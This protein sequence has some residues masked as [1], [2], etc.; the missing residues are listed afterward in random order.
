MTHARAVRAPRTWLRRFVVSCALLACVLLLGTPAAQAD[1]GPGQ[2][3]DAED[4]E[5]SRAWTVDEIAQ[6]LRRDPILVRPSMGMGN[7]ERA[8]RVLT[9]ASAD[10][11]LPV[12]VVLTELPIDIGDTQ[13]PAE[14]AAILLREELG[15]GFYHV[16]FL[17]E[18]SYNGVWGRSEDF[19]T[20]TYQKLR[21]IE[22]DGPGEYPQASVLLE[23]VLSVRAAA[24]GT[25]ALSESV[26][27]GY[28]SQPWAF[29]PEPAGDRTDAEAGRL[30]TTI[31]TGTGILLTGGVI[32]AVAAARPLPARV[33]RREHEPVPASVPARAEN[34]LDEVRIQLAA[35]TAEQL[36]TE[37][38]ERAGTAL[39]AAE[40]VLAA[41]DGGLDAVGALV[42]ANTADRELGRIDDPDE[43]R[44]RPCFVNPLHGEAEAVISVQGTSLEAPVC[45]RCGQRR[46]P[47]L[48][49]RR[50]RRWTPYTETATVWART[51]FGSLVGDLAEQVLEDRSVRQ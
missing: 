2:Q 13:A 39:E 16:R 43:E 21:E 20:P 7:S 11:S 46:G 47:F 35:L 33:R 41:G 17:G 48:A 28:A 8:H 15:D 19:L 31:A 18:G 42:L 10:A 51:G 6:R 34:R 5:D 3:A 38:A 23:A 9:R 50:G 27:E 1:T 22:Q 49:V 14:Q 26:V 24:G 29:R 40:R 37:P 25:D 4:A 36:G 12:Y 32:T 30:V 44:Y 45:A